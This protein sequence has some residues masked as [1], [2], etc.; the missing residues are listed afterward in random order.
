MVPSRATFQVV[1]R[2]DAASVLSIRT[3]FGL[4]A[5][6][7]RIFTSPPHK[8]IVDGFPFYIHAD[9]VAQKSAPLGKLVNGNF[10]EAKDKEG[11]LEDVDHETFS[12]FC[13]WV[14]NGYYEPAVATIIEDFSKPST[15]K[16][17]DP[18]Q[19]FFLLLIWESIL[20]YRAGIRSVEGTSVR[21][22]Q[23][24]LQIPVPN[25]NRVGFS[26]VLTNI[27]NHSS[28]AVP[29]DNPLLSS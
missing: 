7:R 21:R 23:G 29:T 25:R 6:R 1:T 9:L 20:R 3:R 22:R 5:E 4:H 19:A 18:N 16:N 11:V 17:F 2:M 15:R 8:F 12:R 13:Q 10:K 14:Y 28:V 24:A 26:T 27:C